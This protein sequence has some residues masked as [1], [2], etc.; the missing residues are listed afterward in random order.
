MV[1]LQ[2]CYSFYCNY[3]LAGKDEVAHRVSIT[4]SG[5][6]VSIFIPAIFYTPIFALKLIA[7]SASTKKL[8]KHLLQIYIKKLRKQTLPLSSGLSQKKGFNILF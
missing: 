5:T 4:R 8:C 6:S 7:E 2:I 3:L 1:R